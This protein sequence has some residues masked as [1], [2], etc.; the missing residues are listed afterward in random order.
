MSY[1]TEQGRRD[2]IATRDDLQRQLRELKSERSGHAEQLQS[3]TEDEH[4]C[5]EHFD[6]ERQQ[7]LLEQR[8]M[9]LQELIR[10]ATIVEPPTDTTR[11]RIGHIATLQRSDSDGKLIGNPERY[12]VGGYESTDIKAMPP[13]LSYTAPILSVFLGQTVDQT[14]DPTG[15]ILGGRKVF[16]ELLRIELPNSGILTELRSVA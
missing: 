15:I 3:R 5:T 2:L 9:S 13:A 8:I 4:G 1:F 12:F 7:F 16:F 6:N 11:L 10:T 14:R